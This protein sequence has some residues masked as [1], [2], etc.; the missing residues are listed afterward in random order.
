MK[1]KPLL[2]VS[3]LALAMLLFAGVFAGC[4]K[5]EAPSDDTTS[6]ETE[7]QTPT[8]P[9]PY[10][11][12]LPE[13]L[14]YDNATITMVCR[15]MEGVQDEFD[16][17]EDQQSLVNKAVFDRNNA[18]QDR[19]NVYFDITMVPDNGT[20]THATIARMVEQDVMGGGCTFQIVTAPN[21][22]IAPSALEGNYMDLNRLVYTNLDKSYWAQGFNEMASA[23]N[24]QYMATG[25]ATLSLYRFMYVTVYNNR[26]FTE[27]GLEDLFDVVNDNRWTMEYQYELANDLYVD[28]NNIGE[29]DEVDFYGFVSG[30]RTSVDSYWVSCKAW[31]IGRDENNYYT[32]I[33]S[34]DRISGMVDQ[35]LNLYYNCDGSY[36]IPYG[37]DNTDNAEIVNIFSKGNVAMANLKIQAIETGLQNL[38]FEFSIVPLPKY[39]SQ[40]DAYYTNVQDQ[41][42]VISIPR[43]LKEAD[44]EMIGAA[45]EGLAYEGY[46]YIYPAYFEQALSY[47]YLKNQESA[48]MLRLIYESSNFVM[49]YQGLATDVG[50]TTMIRNMIRDK[51]NSVAGQLAGVVGGIP[52]ALEEINGKFQELEQRTQE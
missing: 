33:G 10:E 43:T 14:D 20:D 44:R 49:V 31:V 36:I 8:A 30:A 42:T 7:E 4:R 6:Q 9:G 45:I 28:L 40:Q 19:L 11:C 23:G 26:I 2:R 17:G 47:R 21:Y 1:H 22:T 50:W 38:D 46:R 15:D 52:A 39:D 16:P 35:V 27:R 24:A 25:M 48:D 29:R 12:E 41:V 13:G 34:T 51:S 32:Y 5:E 3:V 18:V 37:D